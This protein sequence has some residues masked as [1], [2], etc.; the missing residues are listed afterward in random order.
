MHPSENLLYLPNLPRLT[1]NEGDNVIATARA[2]NGTSGAQR[3]ATLKKAGAAVL[4]LDI[5]AS[6]TELNE[7]AKE[8]WS[9]YGQVDVLVN[10]AGYIEAAVVEEME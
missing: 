6:Q 8:A 7:K 4:E 3:L 10:N 1:F 5:T 2:S 9:I